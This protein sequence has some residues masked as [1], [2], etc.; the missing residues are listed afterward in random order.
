MLG[1]IHSRAFEL[2]QWMSLNSKLIH[3]INAYSRN[4]IISHALVGNQIVDHSDI[5]AA[6]PDM[7][8]WYVIDVM[9][10]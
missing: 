1:V 10:G 5:V 7:L 6:S 2:F 3:K 4:S 9:Y 8:Q